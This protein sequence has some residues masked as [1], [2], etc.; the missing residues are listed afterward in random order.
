MNQHA[1][2]TAIGRQ[3]AASP[4]LERICVIRYDLPIKEY[5][6]TSLIGFAYQFFKPFTIALY[7][8]GQRIV[9][10]IVKKCIGQW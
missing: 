1:I 4:G 10:Y 2:L 3:P 5:L 7:P 8:K 9:Y 6:G